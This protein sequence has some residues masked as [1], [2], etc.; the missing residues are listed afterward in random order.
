[1]RKQRI[2]QLF[3]GEMGYGFVIG[4]VFGGVIFAMLLTVMGYTCVR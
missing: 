2:P 4:L 1:M 3:L